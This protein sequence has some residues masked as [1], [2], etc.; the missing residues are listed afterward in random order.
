MELSQELKILLE[1]LKKEKIVVMLAPSFVVDFDPESIPLELKQI[2]FYQVV[3]LTFAS[4]IL[5]HYYHEFFN[6]KKGERIIS[7]VCPSC[8]GLI[9]TKYPNLVKYLAPFDSPMTAMNKIVKKRWKNTKT[10]FIG[11]CFAKK[12]EA[13]QYGVDYA[14]T[15]AECRKLMDYCY[16]NDI[17]NMKIKDSTFDGDYNDFT[18]IFPVSGGLCVNVNAEHVFKKSQYISLCGLKDIEKELKNFDK[19]KN[20]IFW[21]L[22]FCEGGCIGGPAVLSER[23]IKERTKIVKDY[24]HLSYDKKI[25]GDEIG[26]IKDAD[27]IKFLKKF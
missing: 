14:L 10:C 19:K 7:S 13:K 12:V 23:S 9:K 18:K 17:V 21:D 16:E 3:E 5:S 11:P 8:V 15:F 26:H 4:K 25:G 2:G 27:G 20:V 22:L 1:K 24:V 6:E